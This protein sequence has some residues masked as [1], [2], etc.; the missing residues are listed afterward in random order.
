MQ[1]KATTPSSIQR[2]DAIS[3]RGTRLPWEIP[4]A[5]AVAWAVSAYA[6]FSGSASLLH[7][8]TLIERGLPLGLA[9]AFFAFAWIVMIAAMML[10]STL[11]MLRLF[12]VAAAKQEKPR[13]VFAAFVLG[14]VVVWTAFGFAAFAGDVV[15]H[16]TV[17]ATP[18]LSA[19]S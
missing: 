15:L 19:H 1:S 17:D 2:P 7:H 5:I 6:Q 11:P 18:W 14:Y 16:R 10:P 3:R 9:L 8:D 4:A 12:V 13:L